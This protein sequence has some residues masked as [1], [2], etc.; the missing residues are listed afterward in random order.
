VTEARVENIILDNESGEVV[1]KGVKVII[2]GVEHIFHAKKEVIVAAGA[3]NSPKILEFSGIGDSKRLRLLGIEVYV[4]N[5]NVG[6]NL[7]DHPSSGMSFEVAD[8]IQTLDALNRQEPEAVSAAMSAYQ[9]DKS[10]PFSGAAISSFAFMPV[11]DFQTPDGKADLVNLLNSKNENS[12][13]TSEF[14]RSVLGSSDKSSACYFVYAA[15]GNFG[16]DSSSAK[17]VTVSDETGSFLT[18]A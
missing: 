10:G 1:A 5:P 12:N 11:P 8:H 3:L 2:Q 14:A 18:I 16:S 9:N 7:Q 13:T 17:N 6:E 15:H 4:D